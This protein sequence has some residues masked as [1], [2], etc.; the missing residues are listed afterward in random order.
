MNPYLHVTDQHKYRIASNTKFQNSKHTKQTGLT[1]NTG[2]YECSNKLE[3]DTKECLILFDGPVLAFR[4]S[5]P[6][7]L[8][9][10]LWRFLQFLLI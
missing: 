1:Q 5:L 6:G 8:F 4:F 7:A 10:R 2:H 9:R 3:L